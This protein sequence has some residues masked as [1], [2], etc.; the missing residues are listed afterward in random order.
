MS[1]QE[2]KD[3]KYLKINLKNLEE[4][5]IID[6]AL[7]EVIKR[8]NIDNKKKSRSLINKKESDITLIRKFERDIKRA[9][10]KLVILLKELKMENN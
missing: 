1:E 2:L 5:D 7:L 8:K 9:K 10:L 4:E 3:I 6:D